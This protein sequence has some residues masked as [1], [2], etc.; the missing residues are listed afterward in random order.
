MCIFPRTKAQVSKINVSNAKG[1]KRADSVDVEINGKR[2]TIE[3]TKELILSAGAFGSPQQLLLSGIGPKSK[4]L[5]HGISQVHDLPGVGENLQD[6]SDYVI[7][8]R[9]NSLEAFGFSLRGGFKF[10]IEMFKY[11]TKRRGML[12]TN[13]AESGAFLKVEEEAPSPDIQVHFVRALVDDHGR[14]L[15]WGHG[16]SAHICILRPKSRGSVNL[17]DASFKSDPEIDIAFLRD[18]RDM[19]LL[20]KGSRKVQKIFRSSSFDEIRGKPLYESDTCLLYTSPSPRD[21]G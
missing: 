8:S 12:A 19:E 17:A 16:Y 14:E 1:V 2:Q 3:A 11:F 7:S 13:F 20:Y 15:Y 21:R 18:E 5:Q 6:H 4:L 9:T 10:L